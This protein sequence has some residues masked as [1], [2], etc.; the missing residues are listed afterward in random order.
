MSKIR[1]PKKFAPL[2]KPKR[3][4]VFYGGRG[5][6]R[7]WSY[8]TAILM[9]GA[10][11]KLR[12]LCAREFQKS[13]DDS[14]H[15]LFRDLIQKYNLP[16]W[17]VQQKTIIHKGTGTT[18]IF[19]GLRYNTNR[20]KSMEGI[21]IC[22]VEEAESVTK[23]NWEILIPTIRKAG[24]EIWISFN[25]ENEEDPTYQR[26]VVNQPPDAFVVKVGW[27]DNPWFASTEM[28][29][30]K[31]YL[32]RVDPE[33]ADY[34]WGGNPKKASDAQILRG[35][36]RVE[37][38]TPPA[39]SNAAQGTK[40]LGPFLG[41]DYGFAED[42]VAAVECW[43]K[44]APPPSLGTLYIHRES[45][46]VRLEIDDIYFRWARDL[47]RYVSHRIIRVDSARPET[48]SYL[49][50]HGIQNIRSVYKW[51]DSV[52]DGIAYLRAFEEIIIHPRCKHYVQECK[53][54]SYKVDPQT[55]EVTT[56]IVD[57]HNHLIDATRYALS[58]MI[59]LRRNPMSSYSGVTYGAA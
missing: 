54:Y 13:I 37:A 45:W 8:A 2:F 33:A 24:S 57:K 41:G 14:V 18:I 7:S 51:P 26:F 29:A 1:L 52:Q 5:A 36:W 10:S 55:G 39:T 21:D 58:P 11:K 16:G 15:A 17:I 27:E 6:G 31:D 25:P 12:V 43:I 4:K 35:K 22:W 3:Y 38:F 19:E 30:E 40:W 23:D 56:D 47:G 28:E 48:T 9:L 53:L 34:V 42:P 44:P 32:Y 46:K 50:R 59:R 20:I 49:K